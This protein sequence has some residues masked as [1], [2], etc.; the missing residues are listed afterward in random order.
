MEQGWLYPRGK[1]TKEFGESITDSESEHFRTPARKFNVEAVSV[2]FLFRNS[3]NYVK[4]NLNS[5]EKKIL[6]KNR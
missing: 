5:N 1:L 6:F 3:K 4:K 2:F